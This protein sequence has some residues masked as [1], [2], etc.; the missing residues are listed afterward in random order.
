MCPRTPGRGIMKRLWRRFPERGA[1][2]VL[3]VLMLGAGSLLGMGALTVDVGQ[4]YVTRERLQSGADA[5]ADAVASVCASGGCTTASAVATQ[6]TRAQSY[7]AA[8]AAR[9]GQG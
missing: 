5:A 4:I 3:V 6:R 2:A 1:A 7:V 8:N 9:A